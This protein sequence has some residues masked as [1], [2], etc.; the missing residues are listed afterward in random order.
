M[1]VWLV[2]ICAIGGVLLLAAWIVRLL[3]RSQRNDRS[4]EG[5]EDPGYPVDN[6]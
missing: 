1:P 3:S 6:D 2:W 5:G 4:W